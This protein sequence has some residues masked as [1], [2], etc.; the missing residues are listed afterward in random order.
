[1]ELGEYVLYHERLGKK[2]RWLDGVPFSEYR[3]RV[4]WSLPHFREYDIGRSEVR[5][6][7]FRGAFVALAVTSESTQRRASFCVCLGPD[8]GFHRLQSR[9]RSQTRRGLE[10]CQVRRVGWDEMRA[11]GLEIN[12]EALRRQGRRSLLADAGWWDR[13][14]QVSAEF[15]DV[16]AWGAYVGDDLAAY[17]HVVMHSAAVG[18]GDPRVAD[19][20]HLMSGAEHL[21]SYPNEALIFTLTNELLALGYKR[22]VFGSGSDD[23]DLLSWKRRMGYVIDTRCYHLVANPMMHL[24]KPFIPKLRIW[25]DGSMLGTGA[26]EGP[27]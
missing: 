19:I 24:V 22:V 4:Y 9:K 8:Y 1:M 10:A 14:C 3:R 7:L 25:M 11:R 27:E 13:Q 12:R 21:K 23:E 5:R 18:H 2:V 6:L 17:A 26:D 16:C 15:D 20:V